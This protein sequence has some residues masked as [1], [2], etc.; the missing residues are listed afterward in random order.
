M[1]RKIW[2]R[3]IYYAQDN[4]INCVN[5]SRADISIDAYRGFDIIAIPFVGHNRTKSQAS[6]HLHALH[7]YEVA[8]ASKT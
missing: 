4:P 8:H 7:L 6:T 3:K 1:S 5:M 2:S